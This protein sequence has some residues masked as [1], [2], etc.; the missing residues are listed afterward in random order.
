MT[1]GDD[2]GVEFS[3]DRERG[4]EPAANIRGSNMASTSRAERAGEVTEPGEAWAAKALF[5][6][7]FRRATVRVLLRARA[8]MKSIT[9]RN[10]N[11]RPMQYA[12]GLVEG[13]VVERLETKGRPKTNGGKA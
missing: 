4:I 2:T 11:T 5:R 12:A 9:A 6:V 1:G 7:R 3:T 13:R 10:Q 8:V